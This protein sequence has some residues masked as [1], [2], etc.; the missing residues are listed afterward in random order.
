MDSCSQYTGMTVGQYARGVVRVD[1]GDDAISN[2]LFD[3]G[4]SPDSLASDLDKRALMLLKAD[5][6]MA[7]A[8][9]PSVSVSVEDADGNWKH[10]ESGGQITEADKS[11]WASIARSIYSRY[12]E[13]CLIKGGPRVHARGMRI[14]RNGHECQ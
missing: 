3:R 1:I 10:K 14:W 9:M 8:N 4:L 6:Y 13:E 7:C 12:G 5:V 2:I 11:R